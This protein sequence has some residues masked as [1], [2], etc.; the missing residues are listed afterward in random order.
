MENELDECFEE[1]ERPLNLEENPLKD[2][3]KDK[4]Y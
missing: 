4:F 1:F 3:K 2:L